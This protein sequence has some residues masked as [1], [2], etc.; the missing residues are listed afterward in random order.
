MVEPLK[1]P[2][3]TLGERLAKARKEAGLTQEEMAEEL[4]VSHST[5]AK[6]EVGAGQPRNF[7]KRLQQW[8]DLTGVPV[9]WLLGVG[10][11]QQLLFSVA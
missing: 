8:A 3:W 9:G 7:M 1:V 10:H 4:D 2:E 6:W 11:E 5:V